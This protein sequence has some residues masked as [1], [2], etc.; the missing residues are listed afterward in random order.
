MAKVAIIGIGA[1]G[2]SLA[3]GL[4]RTGQ[5]ELTLCT[6]RP[7]DG[8]LRVETPDGE[9]SVSASNLTDVTQAEIVDWVLVSTKAYDAEGTA[10]WF[11]RLCGPST[12]VAIVQNGVEHRERFAPF[13]AGEMLVPV[14][15]DTPAERRPDGSVWQ[16]RALQMRVEDTPH[17]SAFAALFPPGNVELVDDFLTA[18]WHKLCINATGA[19]SAILMKPVGVMQDKQLGRVALDLVAECVAVGRAAGAK[20]EDGLGEHILAEDRSRPPDSINSMLAD[21][22]ANRQT[23]VDARHGVI[24]RMGEKYGIPTPANRMAAA[25]IANLSAR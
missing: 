24:V 11:K 20:L 6:R 7:L 4:S 19:V 8:L 2:G 25:L 18:A 9:V 3:A 12:L 14:V 22:L 10:T 15:I 23:E 21:R 16:R 13:L 5:Y 1:I 17:G